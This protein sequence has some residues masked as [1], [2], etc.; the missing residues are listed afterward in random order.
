MSGRI[1]VV[2]DEVISR[3]VLRARLDAAFYEVLLAADG[4]AALRIARRRRPDVIVLDARMPGMDGY[5]VCRRLKAEPATR[6]IAVMMITAGQDAMAPVL[7]LAAGADDFIAKPVEEAV[8]LSRLRRLL[9]EQ[10]QLAELRQNAR[11]CHG[12]GLAE[13]PDTG[14]VAPGVVRIVCSDRAEAG[15]MA[16]RLAALMPHD[17]APA[18]PGDLFAV[19][20]VQAQAEV[21][22]LCTGDVR[23]RGALPALLA[24]LL[25]RPATR[26]A[27]V[28]VLLPEGA[29]DG[30]AGLMDLGAGD[31]IPVRAPLAEIAA[32]VQA[33]LRRRRHMAA[34]RTQ[35]EDGL[36]LAVTDPLTGL[37]NR[38]FAT[39]RL[40]RLA[41]R[42]TR[43]GEPLAVMLLD[44][45]RFK[46]VNDSHGHLAGDA[47]LVGVAERLRRVA[48]GAELIARYGGEEFLVAATGLSAEAARA[49]AEA[50]RFAVAR[51]PFP[52]PGCEEGLKV[53]L[54]AG[55][56][57]SGPGEALPL[58]ELLGA[59]D[60]AL[61]AS[62]SGGRNSVHLALPAA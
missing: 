39:A 1:L 61:Y 3:I 41:D 12:P 8:L 55:V 50:M 58:E 42:C 17:V 51:T 56:V 27:A 2:D 18:L 40:E 5:E 60:R 10:A 43:R 9:R 24:D 6:D 30:G 54:C 14:P 21:I 48:Q 37:S 57:I 35:V 4:S 46:A 33:L 13:P 38:R 36:R 32:R 25:S 7:A 34:L 59:A 23:A 16:A 15:D 22:M 11:A 20:E 29:R 53:T 49:L 44:I 47:V 28:I 45:D 19:G 26:D 52:L 31:C 62:K